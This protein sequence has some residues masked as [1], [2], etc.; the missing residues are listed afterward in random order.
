MSNKKTGF[1]VDQRLDRSMEKAHDTCDAHDAVIAVAYT[2]LDRADT[3]SV[4][5]ICQFLY[6]YFGNPPQKPRFILPADQLMTETDYLLIARDVPHGTIIGTIR[7]HDVGILYHN[8]T[9][10]YAVDCFCIHPGWRRRGV[11]RQ[12]LYRLHSYA[13][14]VGIPYA[15]FLKEGAPIHPFATTLYAGVYAYR[16][17]KPYRPSLIS[18]SVADA[19]KWL[20]VYQQLY[21]AT[22]IIHHPASPNQQWLVYKTR[23]SSILIGVQDTYQ[24]K[25]SDKMGWVTA[26][27]ESACITEVERGEAAE[28]LIENTTFD[29]LWMNQIWCFNDGVFNGAEDKWKSDGAFHWYTYQWLYTASLGKSYCIMH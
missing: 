17:C 14:T 5:G 18:I 22:C 8:N 6:D 26:W 13:N 12:L 15:I 1:F 27:L 10:I 20:R 24:R 25:D 4:K 7:Y 28:K 21:P 9:R 29:Y 3:D 23:S 16:R 11:G 2:W 19:V